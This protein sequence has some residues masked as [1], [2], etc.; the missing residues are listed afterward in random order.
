MRPLRYSSSP[1]RTRDRSR[2]SNEGSGRALTS[3]E[4]GAV[5]ENSSGTGGFGGR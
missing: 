4:T 5:T 2:V 3:I 1:N